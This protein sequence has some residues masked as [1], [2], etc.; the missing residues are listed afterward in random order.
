MIMMTFTA[1]H[2]LLFLLSLCVLRFNNMLCDIYIC[3]QGKYKLYLI[4]YTLVY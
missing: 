4:K 3:G 1:V 2:L